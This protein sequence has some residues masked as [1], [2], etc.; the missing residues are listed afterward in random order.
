MVHAKMLKRSVFLTALLLAMGALNAQNVRVISTQTIGRGNMPHISADGLRVSCLPSGEAWAEPSGAVFVSNENCQLTLHRNGTVSRLTPDGAEAHYIW[1]SLSPDGTRIL[2]NTQHGTS[3]CDL[4]GHKVAYLGHVNAPVWYGNDYVVGHLDLAEDVETVSSVILLAKA[5]GSSVQEL[6]GSNE[7]AYYPSVSASTGRIVYNNQDGDVRLMQLN[8]AEN[9][10]PQQLPEVVMAERKAMKAPVQKARKTGFSDIKIYINPGHGGHGSNDRGMTIYPFVAGDPK[11]FWESNSNLDKGLFL[12]SMLTALGVQTMMSRR[13]NND[14]GGNDADVLRAWL[15]AGKITQQEH[16]YMLA[17]GDDR[18][19]SAIAA[20]ANA[21][22]ADFMLSIHSNAGTPANYIL[23]LYSGKELND[24]RYYAHT[25]RNEAESRNVVNVIAPYLY[26]NANSDWT[27]QPMI[28]GDKT[29]AYRIFG[30]SNG[31]GVLRNLQIGGTISE[32]S[33]HDYT[34]ETYR[35]M[36]MGYKRA[37]AFHFMQAF[38][39]YYLDYTY[40]TGV[41]GGQ[42]RDAYQA[43]T[44][45]AISYHKGTIDGLMPLNRAKVELLQNDVVIATTYTDTL[46]NGCYYFWDLN[47]GTYTV[48]ASMENYYSKEQQVTVTAGHISYWAALLNLQR[49]TPPEVIAHTPAPATLTDS[50]EVSTS[51]ELTFNW[52]MNAD[53]TMAAFSISPAVDGTIS[54]HNANRILRFT[55]SGRL[56]PGVE[57]TVTLSTKACHPD[58]AWPN[59]L[60]QPFVLRFRTKDRG[61][62]RFLG[63]YPQQ[64]ATGVP[65]NPSFVTLFDQKLNTSTV[66]KAFS[67]TD[68][69]GNAVGVNTRSITNNIAP[70]PYGYASFELTTELQPNTQYKLIIDGSL[71]DNIGIMLNDPVTVTFTTGS[72]ETTDIPLVDVLDTLQFVY[73]PEQSFAVISGSTLRNTNRKFRGLASNELRYTF[74]DG[75]GC[76]AVYTMKNKTLVEATCED[77]VGLYV[78]GNFSQNEL[79]A[80]FETEGDIHYVKVCDIDYGGWKWHELDMSVLPA[81]VRLQLTA[82]RILRGNSVLS[83]TGAIYLN[84]LSFLKA[85]ETDLQQTD[86]TSDIRKE[87][88]NGQI[89]IYKNGKRYSVLGQMLK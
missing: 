10:I 49:Q 85:P 7:I 31:Y 2:Y 29:F 50:V 13:T 87:L 26:E 78:F 41:I 36:N 80:K 55:P 30:W 15:S 84:N 24:T 72:V 60:Q 47:P 1:A 69:Q 22:G 70:E 38:L 83:G 61:S 45:P 20:E 76:E 44:F 74:F 62:I 64:G 3:V 39:D 79:Y 27:R 9:P 43:M 14:G 35:L 75:D 11:G 34:P 58:D 65:L 63:S 68:M 40:P 16:D 77:R 82:L 57:Y 5:D 88:K 59:H 17:N 32:G 23:Q 89:Y 56:A 6:T 86:A 25:N 4:Q 46:Y 18:S 19:L 33:M 71:K 81:G 73:D 21:Y 28:E 53:S 54:F 42:V 12:D 48:R 51:I 66:R 52:D 8:L 67:V 37:E